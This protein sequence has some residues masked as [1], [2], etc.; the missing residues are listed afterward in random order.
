MADAF[1]G[2]VVDASVRDFNAIRQSFIGNCI[3]MVLARD[4]YAAGSEVLDRVVGS[5][6]SERQLKG[7]LLYTSDAADE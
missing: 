1:N 7:C 5:S 6:V 2:S 4:V 3:T